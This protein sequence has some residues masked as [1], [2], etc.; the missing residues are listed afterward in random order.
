MHQSIQS[1]ELTHAVPTAQGVDAGR[2]AQSSNTWVLTSVLPDEY[3]ANIAILSPPKVPTAETESTYIGLY[4]FIISVISLSGGSLNESK[5]ERYL[6][7]ANAD[8]YT[9]LDK[10]EKLLARMIKD[11][12]L[13][14]VKDTAGG[15]EVVEYMVGP[16]GKVEVGYDGVAGMVK[17]VYGD[18]APEDLDRRIVRSMGV[19]EEQRRV[20]NSKKRQREAEGEDGERMDVDDDD[21]DDTRE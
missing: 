3:R 17:T 9:P 4:S 7:R 5:L 1:G 12:Y 18:G 20:K 6:R 21:E 14:K 8:E 2:I 15:E 19:E 10:T 13:Y 11:G 16:R